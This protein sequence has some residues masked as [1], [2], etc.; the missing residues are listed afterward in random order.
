M[1]TLGS[2][3]SYSAPAKRPRITIEIKFKK[4]SETDPLDRDAML[5]LAH[6]ALSQISER[7]YD[8]DA[9]PDCA[10]GRMRWGIAFFGRHIAVACERVGRD[11]L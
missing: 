7:A 6:A 9:L 2:L 4:H 8:A 11:A 3:E 1:A 10:D 5:E